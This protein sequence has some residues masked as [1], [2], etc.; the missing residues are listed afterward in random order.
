[1]GWIGKDEKERR[2]SFFDISV[3]EKKEK[4]GFV[5]KYVSTV[6]RWN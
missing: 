2:L 5:C 1:M 3:G 6:V 4:R